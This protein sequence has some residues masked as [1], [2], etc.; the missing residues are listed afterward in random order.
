MLAAVVLVTALLFGPLIPA[1]ELP[2]NAEAENPVFNGFSGSRGLGVSHQLS[3]QVLTAPTIASYADDAVT[4]TPMTVRVAAGDKPVTLRYQL[5]VDDRSTNQTVTVPAGEVHTASQS[6]SLATAEHPAN[7]TLR[8]FASTS[9]HTYT[10][11]TDT[12][13]VN[14]SE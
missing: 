1:G 2:P 8:V 13:E 4:T 9:E 10:V 14:P 12:L 5:V 3:F 7:A 6:L 11:H